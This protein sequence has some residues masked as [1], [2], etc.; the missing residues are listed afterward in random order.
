MSIALNLSAAAAITSYSDLIDEIRDMVDNAAYP[1]SAI[2]SAIRKAEAHFNRVFRTPEMETVAPL[3]VTSEYSNVPEDFLEMRSI[4]YAADPCRDL[5]SYSP[6]GL[7]MTYRGV[8]GS[9]QG[10]AI[11]GQRLRFGPVGNAT[12]DMLYFAAIPA[13]TITSPSNWL[14]DKHADL[15]VA[16]TLYHV[17]RRER[18]SD[19]EA[20]AGN[21]MQEIIA[22]IQTSSAKARWGSGP[23]TPQGIGQVAGGRA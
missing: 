2:D 7:Y 23:L 16:A 15:Y 18:D 9:P 4:R 8:S 12:F 14:L 20:Q 19:G 17:A 21:E 5:I 1:Q 10:Y 13:L 6:A 3:I 22:S 11:E